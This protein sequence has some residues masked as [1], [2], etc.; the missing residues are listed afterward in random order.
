[1][2]RITL[3]Q[4]ETL[5]APSER[6]DR[7]TLGR[8]RAAFLGDPTAVE[9]LEA[10]PGPALVLNRRRQIIALNRLAARLLDERGVERLIG[11]RPGEAFLCERATAGPGGCGTSEQC[12]TC[13]AVNAILECLETRAK[14]V[15]ECRVLTLNPANGGALDLEVHAS[16][17]TIGGEG[18]ILLGMMDVSGE[19]RRQVLERVFFHDLLNYLGGMHGLAQLLL[20][21]E[22]EDEE[23]ATWKR[24]V[25]RLSG[26]VVDEVQAHRR[27]LAAERGE[28]KLDIT[29][30]DLAGLLEE[31]VAFFRHH[32]DGD[33]RLLQLEPVTVGA[34]RTDAALLR[35]IV[36]NLIKNALEATPPGGVVTVSCDGGNASISLGVRNPGVIPRPVQAQIFQRSF[37]TRKGEGRGLGTY[38]V[39]L[40]AE[41]YLGGRVSFVSDAAT[42]TVFVVTL[43]RVVPG[44]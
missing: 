9:M 16:Y 21:E 35:R 1:V 15:K 36:G 13:G 44:T 38:S 26:L 39:R 22:A 40:F 33:G 4:E 3:K 12:A 29:E 18:L 32:P 24:D 41:R 7:L 20:D 30:V 37:S 10:I 6:A 42:G 27:M 14:V 2:S 17:L 34:L 31:S 28:L 43:P 23:K 25:V 5:Y 19:K 8:Q 11:L